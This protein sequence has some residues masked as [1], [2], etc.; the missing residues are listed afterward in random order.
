MPP[1]SLCKDAPLAAF[2]GCAPSRLSESRLAEELQVLQ[3]EVKRCTNL[4]AELSLA[5]GLEGSDPWLQ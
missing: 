3:L 5:M 2:Q 4:D 1:R